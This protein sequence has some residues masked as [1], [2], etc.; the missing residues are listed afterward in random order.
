M[1]TVTTP[2]RNNGPGV[3]PW[4]E[5][6]ASRMPP[7]MS[8]AGGSGCVKSGTSFVCRKENMAPGTSATVKLML[9]IDRCDKGYALGYEGPGESVGTGFRSTL[10]DLVLFSLEAKRPRTLL[11]RNDIR[12]RPPPLRQ[13]TDPLSERA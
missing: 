4:I 8:Y 10:I 9:H 12:P 3:Q 7:G 2:I 5:L 11:S 6:S 13:M 1:A